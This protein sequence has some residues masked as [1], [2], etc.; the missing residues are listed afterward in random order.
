MTTTNP[1]TTPITLPSL[2]ASSAT[3]GASSSGSSSA[4]SFTSN[5]NTFLTLLTTQLQNQDPL[6]PMDTNTFTQQLVSFSE[7]EQQIDTNNN[8]QNLIQLQTAN[9]AISALPL[10]GDQINY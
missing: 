10:I 8:L 3:S 2:G 7:V 6:S 1:T 9:E 5:F 4:L